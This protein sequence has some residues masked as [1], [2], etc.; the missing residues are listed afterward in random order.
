MKK[1]VRILLVF[2]MLVPL[3]GCS[4]GGASSVEIK[5]GIELAL[6]DVWKITNTESNTSYYYYMA[7]ITNNSK[8]DFSTTSIHYRITDDEKNDIKAIDRE[9]L[10]VYTV[11]KGESSFVYGFIGFP[12]QDKLNVGLYFED[13]D[14]FLPFDS[15]NFRENTNEQIAEKGSESF[16]LLDT[17]E[18]SI[19]VDAT[20]ATTTYKEGNT[21]L[22][23][24]V[25]EYKN[26]TDRRIVVPYFL[27]EGTLN[28]L[29]LSDYKDKGDFKK[30]S[31]KELKKVDFS[32]KG[33]APATK[34]IQGEATGY[35]LYY[36]EPNETLKSNIQFTFENAAIDFSDKSKDVY[37]IKLI[38]RAFGSTTTVPL[39]Y[40]MKGDN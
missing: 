38:S 16:T 25:I 21:I 31:L 19:N 33:M 28:G 30:M 35:M 37:T 22:S 34:D 36:L 5:K 27:P 8:K 11:L 40:K 9:D 2:T 29:L 17:K 10:P 3:W 23:D 26:K 39:E 1:L 32:T 13:N 4:K 24:F 20:K 15:G 6:T 14:T 12:N 7:E 18:L